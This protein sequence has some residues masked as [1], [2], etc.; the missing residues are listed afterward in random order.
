MWV[1][2]SLEEFAA[3]YEHFTR[4]GEK[5]IAV[6]PL[7]RFLSG[8]TF[9]W[10]YM[11]YRADE[12]VFPIMKRLGRDDVVA[13][14]EALLAA[15]VGS[16]TVGHFISEWRNKSLV[17]TDFTHQRVEK[18]LFR[19]FDAA[20]Q[21]TQSAYRTTMQALADRTVALLGWFMNSYPEALREMRGGWMGAM[22]PLG[23]DKLSGQGS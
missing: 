4:L 9:H 19:H 16:S 2:S 22:G 14:I 20:D 3:G 6:D 7:M 13:S 12:T 1:M 10:F 15:N 5:C 18:A 23:M 21:A 11:L 8:A 17:H